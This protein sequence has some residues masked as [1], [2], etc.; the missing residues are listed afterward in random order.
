[1]KKKETDIENWLQFEMNE[2]LSET[3]VANK[4][5]KPTEI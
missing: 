3:L 4:F 1:M 2:S 5:V